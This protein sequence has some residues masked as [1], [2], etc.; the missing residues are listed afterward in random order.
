MR[1]R[2]FFLCFLAQAVLIQSLSAQN[3]CVLCHATMGEDHEAILRAFEG[4]IHR[5]A[6]LSCHSCHG[7][8]PEAADAGSAMDPSAGFRGAPSK[9][10]M[11]QF[12]GRCH[13]DPKYM[14]SF[15]PSLPVD[16]ELKYFTS[17][18]G[19]RL[20]AGDANVAACADCHVAHSIRPAK[21]PLSSVHPK[22]VPQ[23]CGHCHSDPVLMSAYHLPTDQLTKYSESVH[24]KA[25]LE[26]GDSAAPACNTCHGNHGAVPPGVENI[27]H[28]C[29]MC[30]AQN[31]EYFK[32]SPMA[33]AWET[34]KY[35]ICATC[36]NHHDIRHPTTEVLSGETGVCKKC[37]SSDTAGFKT[38]TAMKEKLDQVEESYRE[39]G[40]AILAAE[41]RGMD[42]TDAKDLSDAARMGLYQARTAV[43]SFRVETVTEFADKSLEA[44]AKAKKAALDAVREFRWRRIGLG[45]STLLITALIILIYLKIKD[46]ESSKK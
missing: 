9:K 5:Q 30:H 29:G 44:A 23:T 27:A 4:D 43:H 10:E 32:A 34:R 1:Q 37:H 33:K 45:I 15:N 36:H 16:Q 20:K 7:G 18:H 21:D 14:K 28:V 39:T 19:K 6:G 40:G 11:P 3:Q 41:E 24:G 31:E 42:V 46:L 25:L 12:C 38:G 8:D 22:N 35:H 2:F 17:N 26:K 13:S